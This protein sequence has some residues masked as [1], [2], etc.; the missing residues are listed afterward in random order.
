MTDHEIVTSFLDLLA[1]KGLRLAPPL[2]QAEEPV[3]TV[4]G[5]NI[6]VEMT[7]TVVQPIRVIAAPGCS[8]QMSDLTPILRAIEQDRAERA[9]PELQPT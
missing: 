3:T 8:P 6:N 4:T 5:D 7:M 1:R 9:W 2:L